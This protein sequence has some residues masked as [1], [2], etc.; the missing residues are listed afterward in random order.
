VITGSFELLEVS[1]CRAIFIANAARLNRD[2]D[3]ILRGGKLCWGKLTL[4]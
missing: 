3:Q 1:G 4:S 2:A